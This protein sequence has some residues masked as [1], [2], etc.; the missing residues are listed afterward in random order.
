MKYVKCINNDGNS[1]LKIHRIYELTSVKEPTP[2]FTY[3]IDS[4]GN[5]VGYLSFRFEPYYD[6]NKKLSRI[7]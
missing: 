2:G 6:R 1:A 7:L 3:I 4:S 5:V